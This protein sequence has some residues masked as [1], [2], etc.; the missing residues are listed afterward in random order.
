MDR[1]LIPCYGKHEFENVREAITYLIE[2]DHL[3]F[4]LPD[5]VRYNITWRNYLREYGYEK[6]KDQLIELV[7]G[8]ESQKESLLELDKWHKDCPELSDVMDIQCYD[9]NADV[10]ILGHMFHGLADIHNH[11]QFVA[12]KC[13]S[14]SKW[15]N[16]EPIDGFNTVY[17]YYPYPKFDS[18]DDCDNRS[19]DYYLMSKEPWTMERIKA[20]EEQPSGMNYFRLFESLP[21]EFLPCIYR[22][23]E[24]GYFLLADKR[25][26]ERDKG[27][28]QSLCKL[29]LKSIALV[30][31]VVLMV[32]CSE[33]EFDEL[34]VSRTPSKSVGIGN[35]TELP[36]SAR[37]SVY[38]FYFL[39][40]D[41]GRIKSKIRKVT[42]ENRWRYYKCDSAGNYQA[43]V[44]FDPFIYMVDYELGKVFS[45]FSYRGDTIRLHNCGFYP[46]DNPDYS[47]VVV[48]RKEH[49]VQ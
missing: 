26:K 41:T 46:K 35:L 6:T 29:C 42:N 30:A 48:T 44:D 45:E 23:G 40:K 32:S 4:H 14:L 49:D 33:M 38:S 34:A 13:K 17:C 37:W 7:P 16:R 12:Y 25:H 28:W 31:M 27:F 18:Y 20:F 47:L 3:R 21:E 24:K 5:I 22:N 43:M 2:N 36:D 39:D 1:I 10:E 8:L 19:Y 9:I 15:E 11:T